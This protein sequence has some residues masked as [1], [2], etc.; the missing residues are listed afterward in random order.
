MIRLRLTNDR[1]GL[2]GFFVCV[3]VIVIIGLVRVYWTQEV[4]T[5]WSDKLAKKEIVIES[6]VQ[7]EF[8]T[9]MAD[10]LSVAV[11]V[12]GDSVFFNDLLN[13]NP[14][15][16]RSAF[17][18][19]EQKKLEEDVTCEI[20]DPRGGVLC[21][22]GKSLGLNFD[23]LLQSSPRDTLVAV[24][25]SGLY[26]VLTVGI[27]VRS[28]RLYTLASKPLEMN[29]PISNR[30]VRR[31]SFTE[32]LSLK[33][34]TDIRFVSS[35][36]ELADTKGDSRFMPLKD[37]GGNV[38]GGLR[39]G[40]PQQEAVVQEINLDLEKLLGLAVGAGSLFFGWIVVVRL[41]W[42]SSR[43]LRTCVG[44][45]TLWFIRY[46][47]LLFDFPARIIGGELFNP[48]AYSSPSA[49]GLTSS[50]GETLISLVVFFLTVALLVR[51][52]ILWMEKLTL[53]A[54]V[55]RWLLIVAV[56]VAT[57]CMLLFI[58]AYG[59]S[60][61]S[62]VVDS[63]LDYHDPLTTLPSLMVLV[64][65]LNILMLSVVLLGILYTVAAC[66]MK[67]ASH[68]KPWEG[69]AGRL[70]LPGLLALT[71]VL[72]QS[73]NA[74]PI[75]SWYYSLSL[76]LAS[77]WVAVASRARS[78]ES[79]GDWAL[80]WKGSATVLTAAGL[81]ALVIVDSQIH[82]KEREQFQ[83]YA[84]QLLRPFDSWTSFVLTDG[85]RSI[86]SSLSEQSE[87][88]NL[89]DDRQGNLAFS[90]WAKTLL[91]REG[92][93]SAVVVYDDRAKEASR[94]SVGLSA[95]E[96]REIL[97]KVFEY[98]EERV[99]TLDRPGAKGSGRSYGLW[100]TIRNDQGKMIGSVALVLS[101][102][103]RNLFRGEESE[104]LRSANRS[105][106]E[107]LYRT[108]S[109]S[110]FSDGIL[111]G[112]T[113]EE[114]VRDRTLSGNVSRKFSQTGDRS[115]WTE[116]SMNGKTYDVLYVTDGAPHGRIVEIGLER[117]GYQWKMFNGLKLLSC[118]LLVLCAL[119]FVR[120]WDSYRKG[121]MFVLPFRAKLLVSF[122]ALG[123]LPLIL[124]GYYNRIYTAERL[125]Q[126][127][128]KSLVKELDLISQR[129]LNTIADEDD[130]LQ[131]VNNDFA[132]AVSSD[133][134]VDFAV[135]RRSEIQASSR[136]E[137]YEASILDPRLSG[138]VFSE[139]VL[140][141][142]Q[143]LIESETVGSVQYAVGYKAL[144][145][146]NQF[147]GILSVPATSRQREIEDELA[148]RNAYYVAVYALIVGIIMVVGWG[149]AHQLSTPVREL[150][151]AAR[152]VGKGNLDVSVSP[153]SNDEIGELVRSFDQMV[154]EIKSSRANLALAERKLAWN[155][156]AKQVA[157]EIKNPL[158]PM[159]LSVQHLRQ[160]FKDKAKDLPAIME[161]TTQT[162]IDQID[163]LSR[164][165]TE[166]S[167]FAR[168]PE[169]KF[170]KMNLAQI[171]REC[172][173]LFGNIERIEF[174]VKFDDTDTHL[175]GDRDELR[176]AFINIIRNGVQAMDQGGVMT[177]ET[178][179]VGKSCVVRIKD[180]GV[181]IPQQLLPRVFEP[182]FSTK[183]D[184]TGLGLAIAQK[185]IQDLNGTIALASEEKRGT[186]VVITFPV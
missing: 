25:Q 168:M 186:T 62:F 41:K 54:P 172:V 31:S 146:Q 102:S 145:F 27:P 117:I 61:R 89:A 136:P 42:F 131:G 122:L 72:F 123:F 11:S 126:D 134:G 48:Y 86:V 183:T 35:T 24:T 75:V 57:T 26:T 179:R 49:I 148:G 87:S 85:L 36:G 108:A 78:Y 106:V 52:T 14:A 141:G 2:W 28:K 151:A 32:E 164:I 88:T 90:F 170:E 79:L 115:F 116:K 15:A 80:S 95:F 163:A 155:E 29:Y 111:T 9:R 55:N 160:A 110:V 91:S 82:K 157:H 30:F 39:Y 127:L 156:M 22:T 185:I 84:Q 114:S 128:R 167:N 83:S 109:V 169:K 178:S 103:E 47:W 104:A 150:T 10:L 44:I 92:Y 144:Y 182:N 59:A 65:Q 100:S 33:V 162:V 51:V 176:R 45:G 64:M 38:V 34:K 147:M 74:E 133:L 40:R 181:G 143:L 125:D 20:T 166:F 46:A 159:K 101:A 71:F 60:I 113:D 63:T 58:R 68:T 137:L 97:S 161:R 98:D 50:I 81:I 165:A 16:V 12:S 93:N 53:A 105:A 118:T 73:L 66:V 139:I 21:W 3:A 19:L 17:Q 37:F 94:F 99:V 56:V 154:G 8:D 174:R 175:I 76:V 4:A 67:L 184:G 171:L 138:R 13:S 112:T 158:T 18:T 120:A 5:H 177:I 70:V 6:V 149:I 130:F 124:L 23:E 7:K 152:E 135:F 1:P 69:I 119:M 142:G 140:A 132:E 43:A 107:N 180:S 77:F 153:H 173:E 96:Q 129:I 121:G